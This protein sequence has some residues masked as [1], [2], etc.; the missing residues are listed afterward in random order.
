MAART[1][2]KNIMNQQLPPRPLV[3]IQC[4][5]TELF[6]IIPSTNNSQNVSLLRTT[7]LAELKMKTFLHMPDTLKIVLS[8][9]GKIV[10]VLVCGMLYSKLYCLEVASKNGY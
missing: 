5:Y 4:N 1:K 9:M 6:L 7:W 10:F 2:N 3:Q 8:A